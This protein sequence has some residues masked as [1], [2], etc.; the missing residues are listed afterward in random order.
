MLEISG[1]DFLEKFKVLKEDLNT[2]KPINTPGSRQ[3]YQEKDRKAEIAKSLR[4]HRR[5]KKK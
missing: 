2:K 5:R 1:K 3:Y 4:R